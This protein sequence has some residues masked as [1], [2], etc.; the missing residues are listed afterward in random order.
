MHPTGAVA[1]L[2]HDQHPRGID[3]ADVLEQQVMQRRRGGLDRCERL[4]LR[5]RIEHAAD[6]VE[7]SQV[8]SQDAGHVVTMQKAMHG[9]CSFRME[10]V[11][12]APARRVTSFSL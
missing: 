1:G 10:Q 3:V 6:T 7:L 11:Y 9:A 12:D 4:L 8:Q 2:E 5:R